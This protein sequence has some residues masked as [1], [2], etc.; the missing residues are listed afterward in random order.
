MRGGLPI[1]EILINQLKRIGL[2]NMRIKKNYGLIDRG[3]RGDRLEPFREILLTA[4]EVDDILK[5]PSDSD[6]H[7][8]S[9]KKSEEILLSILTNRGMESLFDSDDR[10][11]IWS[12]Y[13]ILQGKILK[14]L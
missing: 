3:K 11:K 1:V 6:G 14:L 2:L 5:L 7:I 12:G 9:N 4:S 13:C 8:I 10:L